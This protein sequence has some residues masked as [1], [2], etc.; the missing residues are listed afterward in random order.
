MSMSNA[1]DLIGYSSEDPYPRYAALR[2]AAA[3]HALDDGSY[4]MT[5][6]DDVYTAI[7]D[8]ELFS[9][10]TA[11]ADRGETASESL[12]SKDPPDHT[13][14]RQLV[15][16]PFRPAAIAAMEPT[17][18]AVAEQ[19]V[20]ELV[21]ANRDGNAELVDQIAVPLPV[22]AIANMMGIP[23]DRH[24]DFRRWSDAAIAGLT[25][26]EVDAS[27]AMAAVA[28]MAEFFTSLI[29]ERRESPGDDLISA[30]AA[31]PEALSEQ[32]VLV[33]CFTLL[34]AGNETTTNLIGNAM[35]ALLGHPDEMN[36]LWAEPSL[37]PSAMEEALRFDPPAQGVPRRTTSPTAVAGCEIPSDA[38]VTLLLASANRDAAHYPDA[39]R[40]DVT[41]NPK[42]HVAF[43]N[44]VH[45]CLG[46][47]LARLEAR[48]AY[49]TLIERV[50]DVR[51]NGPVERQLGALRGVRSLPIA[52][53]EGA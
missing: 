15:T 8:H 2:D 20:D 19:L 51:Q 38:T 24:K 44:G 26:V 52:F 22:I 28:E 10:E 14:L 39:D 16:G 32:E 7:R 6:Y 29:G 36:R 53:T 23:P 5:R 42:D 13:R 41:R 46:A 35:L 31:G 21:V 27:E 37:V 47:S 48:L 40:F 25:G 11:R 45:F 17:I 4:V 1:P 30:V 34:V 9:S 49:E 3:V 18:R 12:I 33:F 43:G 50:R